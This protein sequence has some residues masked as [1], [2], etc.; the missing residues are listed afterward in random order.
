MDNNDKPENI[1]FTEHKC[2]GIEKDTIS[3]W[4]ISIPGLPDI[5]PIIISINKK[6]YICY[7]YEKKIYLQDIKGNSISGFPMTGSNHFT[8]A[9]LNND[10]GA[11][12]ILSAEDNSLSAYRIK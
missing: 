1:F 4:R 10:G 7:V 11:I 5:Q 12:L 8:I 9:D 6:P 3:K 2:F